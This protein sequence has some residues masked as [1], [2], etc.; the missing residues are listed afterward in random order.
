M[1]NGEGKLIRDL[2]K[3]RN[4]GSLAF[5]TILFW[6]KCERHVWIKPVMAVLANNPIARKAL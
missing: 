4:E 2:M 5:R 6:H 3:D 1:P